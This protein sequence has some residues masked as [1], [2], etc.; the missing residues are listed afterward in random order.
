MN[1]LTKTQREYDKNQNS[2]NE[3]KAEDF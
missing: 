3:L 2:M 1:L